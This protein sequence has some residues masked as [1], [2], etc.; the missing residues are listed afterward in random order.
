[1]KGILLKGKGR[2]A[3]DAA[4]LDWLQDAGHMVHGKTF[5][6]RETLYREFASIYSA[7]RLY[8]GT[9]AEN[10]T[11]IYET[12]ILLSDIEAL[13]KRAFQLFGEGS[14][15]AQVIKELKSCGY[16]SKNAGKIFAC[17]DPCEC[18]AYKLLLAGQ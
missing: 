2:V 17:L 4:S 5:D 16:A 10:P 3:F 18:L 15:V 11:S 1:M 6:A 7:V 14:E 12:G 8:H 13:T 9:C